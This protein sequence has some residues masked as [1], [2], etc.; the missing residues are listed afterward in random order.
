MTTPPPLDVLLPAD[1]GFSPITP[2]AA[3]QRLCELYRHPVTP[4]G[5][6]RANMISS[7]D[8]AATG[9]DR[10]SGSING[11]ADLRVFTTLRALADVVLVGAGTVRA[12]GYRAPRTSAPLIAGRLARGQQ[13]HPALAVVSARGELP[14]ALLDDEPAPWVFTTEDAPGLT[15]LRAHLP[16]ERLRVHPARVDLAQ[17]RS[18]LVAQGLSR[19]L[20]E[21][22]PS[23]LGDLLAADLV[24]ELCLTTSPLVVGGPVGRLVHLEAWIDPPRDLELGHL[25][26]SDGVLLGRWLVRRH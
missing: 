8:G 7:V 2:D 13:P 10:R 17:V 26:H 12:E 15:T 21:G 20:T 1:A 14:A 11:P 22:G 24:D 23:L 18:T 6:F 9:P 3:E 5:W 16:P 25:L 19:I 4:D